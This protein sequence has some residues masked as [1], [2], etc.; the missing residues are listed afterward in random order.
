MTDAFYDWTITSPEPEMRDLKIVLKGSGIAFV[1]RI[2]VMLLNVLFHLVLARALGAVVVG[3]I[4]IGITVINLASVVVL[5]G[6]HRGVLRFV[7]HYAGLKDQARIAGTLVSALRVFSVT[8]VIVTT[9]ILVSSSFIAEIV[10]DKPEL[11]QIF[12]IL[13]FSIPFLSLSK[14]MSSYLQALRRIN[15]KILIDLLGPLLNISG[16]IFVLYLVMIRERGIVVVL[17]GSSVITAMLACLLTWRHYPLR[18]KK[19]EKPILQT[20]VM[21][22]FSWPLLLT[23]ILSTANA[24]SETLVLGALT[25]SDQVGIYFVAFKAISLI[26]IFLTAFNVIF[27]PMISDLYSKG[28]LGEMDHL[29]KTITRWAFTASLPIFL[30]IFIWSSEVLNLFGLEF[31][32]GSGVLRVL[33]ASQILWVLSGPSGWMLTMTGHPR[34]N[35]LN[36]VL[37][38]SI[39]L[40]LDFILIPRYG[41]MGAAIGGAASIIIVNI[42][43]LVGVY[44]LLRMQPYTRSYFKPLLAGLAASAII[45]GANQVFMISSV[46]WRLIVW[47]PLLICLYGLLLFIFRIETTDIN[48]L[49]SILLRVGVSKNRAKRAVGFL[50]LSR[51]REGQ[52]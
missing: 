39:A 18:G 49:Y 27:A 7:A 24:Q 6:L 22:E 33:A 23:A 25:T 11:S 4:S 36:M 13:A 43:R 51:K 40:G 17:A 15:S 34:F 9:I 35:L 30:I 32:A 16:I 2:G 52:L 31:M 14:I 26:T 8:A 50:G 5:F 1:G 41:A 3:N 44:G 37:T 29:Y 45:T 38:L 10:F 46:Y 19:A 21:I 12:S 28:K 48:I 47:A 20:R 42:V